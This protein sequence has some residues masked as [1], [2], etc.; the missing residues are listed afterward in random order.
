MH[1][2]CP[3]ARVCGRRDCCSIVCWRFTLTVWFARGRGT[4]C[5]A[6][7]KLLGCGMSIRAKF[8]VEGVDKKS[9][10]FQWQGRSN[11]EWWKQGVNRREDAVIACHEAHHNQHE[12]R[13]ACIQNPV[14][15]VVPCVA[16]FGGWDFKFC[17]AIIT[18]NKSV[19]VW[20]TFTEQRTSSYKAF[21]INTTR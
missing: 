13:D 5:K 6:K 8:M 16:T 1:L 21:I 10:G 2:T 14:I 17:T 19:S 18:Q 7:V 20:F 11:G 9:Y 3:C 4:K 12:C 15:M